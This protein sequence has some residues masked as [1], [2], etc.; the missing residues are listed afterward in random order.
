[1]NSEETLALWRQG[2]EAW[3]IWTRSA[4]EKKEALEAAG[5]WS[6]DWYG[7]GQNEDSKTW[8]AEA[9]AGFTGAVFEDGADFSGM[10]FPGPAD[11]DGAQFPG[12][13]NFSGVLF[14]GNASFEGAELA[15]GTFEG[16]KFLGCANFDK[17][18]FAADIGFEKAEFLKP[19]GLEPCIRFHRARFAANA[20]FSGAHFASDVL[21]VKSLFTGAYFDDC[22]FN[23]DA[24]FAT[25]QFDVTANFSKARFKGSRVDFGNAVF[26]GDARFFEVHFGVSRGGLM[27][28]G[29]G[30]VNFE[31]AQFEREASFQ[32]TWFIG[33]SEFRNA[34]FKGAAKFGGT[35]FG[36]PASFAAAVFS[37]HSSFR[38]AQFAREAGFSGAQFLEDC[39]F[40]N[41]IF[42]G[43]AH[44][45]KV[46][47]GGPTLFALARFSGNASFRGATAKAIFAL[48]GAR[49]AAMPDLGEANFAVPLALN[50]VIVVKPKWRL[51]RR[52]LKP[53]PS[54]VPEVEMLASMA[55]TAP[56]AGQDANVSAPLPWDPFVEEEPAIRPISGHPPSRGRRRSMLKPLLA[57]AFTIPAFTPFY[58]S[59]RSPAYRGEGAHWH[60]PGWPAS[61][62]WDGAPA[63]ASTSA[64]WDWVG[65]LP[66]A[67][68]GLFSTGPCVHGS[69]Q[70]VTEA[71]F[72]AAKNALVFVPWED[73]HA[74]RRVY[75]C[76]Y[77]LN[78]EAPI[79]P[80]AVSLGSLIQGAASAALAAMVIVALTERLKRR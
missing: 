80:V 14:A 45:D 42:G 23:G 60:L 22:E 5:K 71:I 78:A 11:F 30:S 74:A 39:D 31:S 70:A 63:W 37:K 19:G 51:F 38:E 67:I 35:R 6:V 17:V 62:S 55:E 13:A 64:N 61:L 56:A 4:V 25:T 1:M 77:G 49:C 41:A 7:E 27:I 52:A 26:R 65:W 40:T 76:L 79:I 44:F 58:L 73:A 2:R 48:E 53:A 66:G 9:T 24:L 15:G 43:G 34:L 46:Q 8:L 20:K 33:E 75:G 10:H 50:R 16:A 69:S 3:E 28:S 54:T 32:E 47:F 29:A 36:M 72:L 21:F 12:A 68:A 59:Q 57:W 18:R